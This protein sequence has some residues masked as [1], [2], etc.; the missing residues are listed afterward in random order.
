M[1][2]GEESIADRIAMNY[3]QE[4]QSI[5]AHK[6]IALCNEDDRLSD[7]SA[8]KLSQACQQLHLDDLQTKTSFICA[9]TKKG[10]N[11]Y[12]QSYA[13]YANVVNPARKF[14]REHDLNTIMRD[15]FEVRKYSADEQ[16]RYTLT[17]APKLES[18][19][20]IYIVVRS[21][22]IDLPASIL[23]NKPANT[24]YNIPMHY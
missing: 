4:Y 9:R 22:A 14:V 15:N 19:Y 12:P 18:M 17:A 21:S 11:I 20:A 24:K 2:F 10:D 16:L 7:I 6:I 1:E 8:R 13:I 3:P 23:R 5:I